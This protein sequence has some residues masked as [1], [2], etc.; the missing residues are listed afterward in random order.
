MKKMGLSSWG[1]SQLRISVLGV[2][3][4]SSASIPDKVTGYRTG[5]G[6]LLKHPNGSAAEGED[7]KGNVDA[8]FPA[9]RVH[10]PVS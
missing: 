3:C 6:M 10:C 4:F 9:Q 1:Q 5:A 7:K 2:L 8:M